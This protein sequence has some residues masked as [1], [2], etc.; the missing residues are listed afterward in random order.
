MN[1]ISRLNFFGYLQFVDQLK[2]HYH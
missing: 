2:T 1:F